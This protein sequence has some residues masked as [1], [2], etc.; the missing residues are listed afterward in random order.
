M[1]TIDS[2]IFPRAAEIPADLNLP[3]IAGSILLNGTIETTGFSHEEVFAACL[4]RQQDG[5]LAPWKLGTS[6]N[7]S[8]ETM[9]RAIDA[10]SAAWKLGTGE[11]PTSPMG[12]RVAAVA[13][14]RA[15]MATVR[16]T[17]IALLMLEIGKNRADATAEFDRTLQY[18]DDTLEAA[19]NLDRDNSRLQFSGGII[20]QIRRAPLG[21]TLCMGPYNY[22]L[23]E[24]FT[25]LIPAILMG[26]TA[27]VKMARYGRLFW[28]PLLSAFQK[29]FPAGVVNILNGDGKTTVTAA[30]KTGKV[31]ILAF[32]GSSR[33]GDMIKAAHPMPHRLRSILGLDAKN[34][35]IILPDADLNIAV[36]ECVRGALSFNGQRCTAIKIIFVHSSIAKE[37]TKKL[38][39]AVNALKPGMPWTDGVAI[40]PLPDPQKPQALKRMLEEAVSRGAKLENSDQGGIIAG[41]IFFPAVLSNV[42]LDTELAREEQFG[43][44]VPVVEYKSVEEFEQYVVQSNYGQQ[45]AIFGTDPTIIGSLIDRLANQICRINLNTQCQRGPDAYPFTGRKNSAEGTLS[46]GDALRAFS[47]RSMVAA[48]HDEVGKAVVQG[49]LNSDTSSFLCTDILL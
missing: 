26:N 4:T 23:N 9:L 41:Q 17:V 34:P 13:R 7:V 38:A 3:P 1:R 43:P 20:A 25:T 16:G 32:I 42:P 12:E 6:P 14:F 10:A 45:A 5:S 21:V 29:N 40:T 22:P 28:E 49:V 24:T 18:I 2:S 39:E 27:V 30:M 19:R 8:V 33:V 44:I 31:D 46:V 37:F 11:W 15:D 36:Q 47:I 35:A 48:K